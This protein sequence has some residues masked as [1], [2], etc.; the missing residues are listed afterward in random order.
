MPL[1]TRLSPKALRVAE[2]IAARL[3]QKLNIDLLNK[4]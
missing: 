1:P 3:A 4:V 2:D